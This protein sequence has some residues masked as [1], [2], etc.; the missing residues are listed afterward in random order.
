MTSI[1]P[2]REHLELGDRI[3]YHHRAAVARLPEKLPGMGTGVFAS[4]AQ[5]FEWDIV[6]KEGGS[7]RVAF[8]EIDWLKRMPR[9]GK[10]NK[11]IVVWPE[12]GK[13]FVFGLIR[14]GVGRSHRGYESGYEYPEWNPGGFSVSEWHWLYAVKTSLSGL[15]VIYVPLWAARKV[16]R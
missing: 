12:E 11:T 1:A 9:N 15:S 13:G 3:R 2:P 10:L 5:E 8:E 16:S 7:P 6:S 4:P 14:R